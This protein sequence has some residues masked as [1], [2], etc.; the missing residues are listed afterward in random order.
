[1]AG[2]PVLVLLI[3]DND[4]HAELA[5]RQLADHRVA[6]RVI[7]LSDG[8]QAVDYLFRNGIFASPESSPRPHIVL[9]DLRLPKIDGLEVLHRLKDSE[10]LRKIP[11]VVLATS[12]AERDVARAYMNHA[13]SFVVKPVDFHK[14]RELMNDLGFYWLSWN[15]FAP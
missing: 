7:R 11:V 10:D 9:L 2:E 14:F 1:M 5:T 3:E 15:S 8:Q 6:N 13:N 4:D 12:E